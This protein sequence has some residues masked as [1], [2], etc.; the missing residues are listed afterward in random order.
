MAQPK[1]L[2]VDDEK[3]IVAALQYNLER[4]GY[5]TLVAEDGTGA[6]EIARR[7]AP[8]LILLDWMLPEVDG[9]E[10]CR[11]LRAEETTRAIPIILLTVKS[12]E[13][14]KV[15][16]LELGADD[17]VTKPFGQRELL[18]RVRAHLRRA[19]AQPAA[20][21]FRLDELRIDWGRHLVTLSGKPVE[22]THKEFQLLKALVEARGRVL[23]RDQLLDRVWGYDRAAQ[24]ETRTVD[25]HVSQ[26]RRKL[27]PVA[28]R[29]VTLK[30]V[31]YR[32]DVDE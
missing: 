5:R 6:L 28:R 23:T 26:L 16:G 24:I 18:A 25:L 10:V 12:E 7:E 2:I 3:N 20:E 21:T 9:L 15:L 14:D 4:E 13:T 22:L 30:S 11:R 8:D 32:F 27:E 19:Q 31:G 1:I 17:F 29:I